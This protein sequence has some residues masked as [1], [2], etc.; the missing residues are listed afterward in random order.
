MALMEQTESDPL[1]GRIANANFA[2]YLIPV[3]ADVGSIEILFV[4]EDDPHVNAL[5]LK[6]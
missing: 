3:N 1:T 4:P 5:G 2:D 6:A